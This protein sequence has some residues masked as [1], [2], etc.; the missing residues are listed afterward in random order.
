[1]LTNKSLLITGAAGGIGRATALAAAR[2][3]ALLVVADVNVAGAAE[4]ASMVRDAGGS[5][6]PAQCD[7]TRA[8]SVKALV[9]AVLDTYGRLDGAFNNAGIEGSPAPVAAQT[10][11][12]FDRVIAVNLKGV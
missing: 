10:E 11:D 4:T 9:E 3:G 5:A 6:V 2:A 7:V 8:D 1:M 12:D